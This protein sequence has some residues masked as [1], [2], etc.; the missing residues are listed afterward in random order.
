MAG[1]VVL[2]CVPGWLLL[3]ADDDVRSLSNR[4][5]RL[6]EQGARIRELT[7][8]DLGTQLY[9]VEAGSAEELLRRE[10]ALGARLRD[11][12]TKDLLGHYHAI[13]LLVPSAARQAENREVFGRTVLADR[14]HLE[15]VFDQVGLRKGIAAQFER[16]YRESEGRLLEPEAWLATPAAAPFRHLWLG[17]TGRGYA[18]IVVPFGA[19]DA[20]ALSAAAEAVEGATFLDKVASVTHLFGQ[21]RKAFTYGLAIAIVVVLA[22]LSRRYRWR[23]GAA[24]LLPTLLGIAGSL[25]LAGYAGVPMTLFSVMA[26]M[27]VLGVGVNY[28]IFLIEG[29]GREG[30]AFVA[31][32]LSAATTVLS[33][34]LL[35]F[36]GTPALAQFGKTLV[37]GIGIAVLLTPLAMTLSPARPASQ[38]G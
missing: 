1:V 4:A 20:Q 9:L 36:S 16:A 19:R 24:V 17:K 29:R 21:Y 26:L 7:G 3:R 38:P 22:V 5:P 2:A 37:A 32:L 15:R 11:L 6:L 14:A 35:A 30:S 13:S 25:A 18:S 28:A 10:E 12:M 34:G 23:G 33:F 8:F 31:V 27:L